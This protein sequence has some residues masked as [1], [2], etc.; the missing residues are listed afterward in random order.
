MSASRHADPK[1]GVLMGERYRLLDV[2]GHGGAGRVY[3]AIQEPIGREVAVKVMHT[4]LDPEGAHDFQARF[5]RE[6]ATAG[7]VQHPHVV[8]VHDYGRTPEGECYIVMEHLRGRTLRSVLRDGAL[9]VERSLRIFEQLVRGLRAAHRAGLVHRDVKPSNVILLRADDGGDFV[10]LFDFGLVKGEDEAAIT[11]VGMFM[12]TP[13]YV[14]PEQAKGEESDAR[15]DLYSAG[16]ILYRMVTGALP[17]TADTPLAVAWMHVR[18]ALPAMVERAPEVA[19]PAALEA[20]VRR[21]LAKEPDERYA[22]ADAVLAAVSALRAELGLREEE[23]LIAAVPGPE[24]A[25]SLSSGAGVALI[26]GGLAAAPPSRR[27]RGLAVAGGLLLLG[28]SAGGLVLVLDGGGDR[29]EPTPVVPAVE[30][31]E[32]PPVV[33]DEQPPPPHEVTILV[34]SEPGGAEVWLDDVLLGFT[35]LAR[36]LAVLEGEG[37]ERGLRL[38]LEGHVDGQVVLDLDQDTAAGHLLLQ[39]VRR[40]RSLE[41][42]RAAQGKPAAVQVVADGVRFDATQSAAALSWLNSA[43]ADTLRASGIAARQVNI[44][45]DGRPFPD[46]ATFAATPWIGPKT[47]ERLLTVSQR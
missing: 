26:D 18:E 16:V 32:P 34:S 4:E 27:S 46:L 23:S 17:F 42:S 24:D 31:V 8:T 36:S 13:Q 40:A 3:R 43:D 14:A 22:D 19:V 35:P 11:Q 28:A 47:L 30:A 1:I 25:P 20:L 37:G 7:R 29:V 21:L 10:K 5:L 45:V 44:I 12:G 39:P 6:A 38:A 33:V 41:A 2:I 9:P 15:S